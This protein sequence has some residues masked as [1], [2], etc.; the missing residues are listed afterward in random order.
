[1]KNIL[2]KLT[3]TYK[4]ILGIYFA[5]AVVILIMVAAYQ[6]VGNYADES[7]DWEGASGY[8]VEWEVRGGEVS[9]TVIAND[10]TSARTIKDARIVEYL[11]AN[12][13]SLMVVITE[14][15]HLYFKRRQK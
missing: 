12:P 14:K 8:V 4:S 6:E 2:N 1:M 15:E 11:S 7:I 9:M 13:D 5:L 3:V 10:S